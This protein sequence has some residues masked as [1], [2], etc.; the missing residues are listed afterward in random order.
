MEKQLLNEEFLLI[1]DGTNNER[2]LQYKVN[3]CG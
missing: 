3:P 1:I 2:K